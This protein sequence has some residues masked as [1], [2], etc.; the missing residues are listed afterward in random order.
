MCRSD[1]LDNFTSSKTIHY[2]R[3]SQTIVRRWENLQGG[4]KKRTPILFLGCQ[5][6]G[7]PCSSITKRN[8]CS[9]FLVLC[10]YSGGS[11]GGDCPSFRYTQIFCKEFDHKNNDAYLKSVGKQVAS[12]LLLAWILHCL[13]IAFWS[14]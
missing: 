14:T 7:P 11:S 10:V 2:R 6:F 1:T 5:L 8:V 13:L 3:V 9:L 4:P 12:L